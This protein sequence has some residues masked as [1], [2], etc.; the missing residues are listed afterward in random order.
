MTHCVDG[1]CN[2][3]LQGSAPGS[4]YDNCI[5]IH[6]EANA[7]L[8]SY[9]DREGG[10]LFVNGPPCFGCMKQIVNSGISQVVCLRD[11]SYA[12]FSEVREYAKTCGVRVIEF[13]RS[14]LP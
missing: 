11:E 12:N 9:A 13:D 2:R 3:L 7:L 1:G 8:Y 10:T 5:S 6:A 4:D 14:A